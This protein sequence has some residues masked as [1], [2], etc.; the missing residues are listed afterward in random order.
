[1]YRLLPAKRD[2]ISSS[3]MYCNWNILVI[4]HKQGTVGIIQRKHLP[5]S[6]FSGLEVACWPLVHKF[7]G[8]NPTEAVG[9]FGRK[10]PSFGEEVKPSVPCRALRHVKEPKSDVEVVTF[11]KIL[12]HFSPIVPPSAASVAS[13][14]GGFLWRKLERSKSLVLL[15][16]EGLTYRWQRHSVK[17]SC[18]GCW[19]IVDQAETQ[20]RV[21]VSIEEEEK[22]KHVPRSTE[23]FSVRMCYSSCSIWHQ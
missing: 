1:M 2:S 5:K 17:P 10:N 23:N 13:D 20:L 19:T 11:G 8:S 3:L 18:W 7:A 16:V 9:F 4:A 14:A 21:V 6:S 22:K 15:Q 12:G